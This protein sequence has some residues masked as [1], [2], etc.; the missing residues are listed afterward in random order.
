MKR[1]IVHIDR[2][3]LKG[4]RHEDRHAIALGLQEQLR[5]VFVDREAVSR[6]RAKGD[7]LRLQAVSVPIEHGSKPPRVGGNVARGIGKE[8]KK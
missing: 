3:A 2:L 7:L 4:F 6:L 5:H 8:I 1:V